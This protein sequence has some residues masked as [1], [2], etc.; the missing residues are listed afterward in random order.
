MYEG[1][2]LLMPIAKRM[3]ES[4]LH[5]KGTVLAAGSSTI[6]QRDP[7]GAVMG[8]CRDRVRPHGHG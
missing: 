2:Q 6:L 7:V 5:D 8:H 3:T 4:Q 1:G